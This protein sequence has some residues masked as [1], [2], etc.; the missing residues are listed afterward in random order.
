MDDNLQYAA[1]EFRTT[2][3]ETLTPKHF[4]D[5]KIAEFISA[6]LSSTN[7]TRAAKH[8]GLSASDGRWLFNQVDIYKCITTL[9]TKN[10]EKFG[11]QA[12]EVVERTR[13]IANLD[14]ADLFDANG[15]IH[16]NIHDIPKHARHAI[17]S[18]VT[19]NIF[20]DDHNGMPQY[21]GKLVK[22]E[23]WDKVKTNELL[24]REKDI[25]K[26]TDVV[27]HDVSKNAREY[28]LGSLNRASE[29]KAL[30]APPV[31]VTPVIDAKYSPV[32]EQRA[33]TAPTNKFTKPKGVV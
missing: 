2:L 8:V 7:I 30:M 31:D 26:K 9:Q 15:V 32:S 16:E 6:Y 1:L 25:F 3:Q 21:K 27:Q 18:I 29:A 5:P 17:K 10:V 20:E 22:V 11:Y 33:F 12:A 13:E 24:A 23:F 14:P 19:K 4:A 28:L